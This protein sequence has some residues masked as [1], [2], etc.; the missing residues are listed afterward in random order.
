MGGPQY[1]VQQQLGSFGSLFPP[2]TTYASNMPPM[3]QTTGHTNNNNMQQHMQHMV[4][5]QL[6]LAINLSKK[7]DEN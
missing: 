7:S 4:R 5:N 3:P 2:P 6:I 1:T